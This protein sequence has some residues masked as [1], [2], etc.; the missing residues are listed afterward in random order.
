M[1]DSVAKA[2]A[3]IWQAKGYLPKIGDLA[4]SYCAPFWWHDQYA[5]PPFAVKA[6]GTMTF[7]DT[8][9]AKLGVT[10]HHVLAEWRAASSD[11]RLVCQVGAISFH[12]PIMHLIDESEA[13]DLA[14]FDVSDVF[15]DGTRA[16]WHRPATWPPSP[17]V[18]QGDIVVITGYPGVG[19]IELGNETSFLTPW[20][21]TRAHQASDSHLAFGLDLAGAHAPGGVGLPSGT[22]LGGLSGGPVFRVREEPLVTLELVGICYQGSCGIDVMRARRASAIA[23]DGRIVDP[24]GGW[25]RRGLLLPGDV[26]HSGPG[27]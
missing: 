6:N 1:I 23:A 13:A 3:D 8:G 15:L 19:R 9:A 21:L 5:R 7:I 14:V 11:R 16:T 20:F 26:A 10:A 17:E 25:P 4:K 27:S 2:R 24:D 12:E 18:Q 22:D